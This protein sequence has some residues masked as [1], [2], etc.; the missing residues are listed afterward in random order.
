[1]KVIADLCVVPLGV[2]KHHHEP[3]LR[4]HTH[5]EAATVIDTV[6]RWQQTFQR[7]LGRRVAHAA[8]EYY[9]LAQRPFPPA[10]A[11]EDFAMHEDGVGIARTFE[12][13]FR[14][15]VSQA[16]GPASGFFA[17]VE[18]A[19]AAGQAELIVD[20]TST[21]ATLRANALKV[22]DDGVMLRSEANLVASL[23]ANWNDTTRKLARG[24]LMRISAE[25]DARA[26]R[27]VRA[28]VPDTPRRTARDAVEAFGVRALYGIDGDIV[29]LV[30]PAAKVTALAEWLIERGAQHISVGSLD[31]I[32]S[33]VNPLYDKLA[34]RL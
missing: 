16:T 32:F 18:G 8:D 2:S 33:A 30:C 19:P 17:W 12:A 15:E 4:S 22:L 3:R 1:M 26:S 10:S 27:E 31:Y 6:E 20:I 13:E 21:G 23:A 9:L 34:A 24:I 25:E 7:H 14:G 28:H 11:Y 29:R 5:A